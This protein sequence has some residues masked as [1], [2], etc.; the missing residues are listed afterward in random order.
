M[1]G[2]NEFKRISVLTSILAVII[3][4]VAIRVYFALFFGFDWDSSILLYQ[5]QLASQG[6]TMFSQIRVE[7]P[8]YVY[9]LA[10]M[11]PIFGAQIWIFKILS[12]LSSLVIAFFVYLIGR[13]LFGKKIGLLSLSLYLLIPVV[14]IFDVQGTYRTVFQVPVVASLFLVLVGL[15]SGRRMLLVAGGLLTGISVFLYAGSLFYGLLVLTVP[16]VYGIT[17]SA[18]KAKASLTVFIGLLIGFGLGI[19]L[20]ILLGSS[21]GLIG[22]G[23][24][25]SIT[26][27]ASGTGG[28]GGRFSSPS[29]FVNYLAYLTRYVYV[30]TRDWI[31]II[32][33]GILYLVAFMVSSV[34]TSSFTKKVA[35]ISALAIAL[36]FY[37]LAAV[38][39]ISLP[40]HGDYGL[41]DVPSVFATIF[42]AE[43]LVLIPLMAVTLTRFQIKLHRNHHVMML[44]VLWLLIFLASFELPHGFYFQFFAAPLCILGGYVVQIV[45]SHNS[46]GIGKQRHL[47]AIVLVIFISA[48][49]VLGA[50]MFV[51]SNINEWSL[52]AQ[53]VSDVGTYLRMHTYPGDYVFTAAPIY[54]EAADRP[55]AGNMDNYFYFVNSGTTSINYSLTVSKIYSL[56]QNGAVKYVILDPIG[57]TQAFIGHYPQIQSFFQDNYR[58]TARIDGA[59]IWEFQLGF[60]LSNHLS[61]VSAYTGASN[62][63]MRNQAWYYE[64]DPLIFAENPSDGNA[65][66]QNTVLP[67]QTAFEPPPTSSDGHNSSFIKMRFSNFQYSELD[68]M[69]A[70]PDVAVQGGSAGVRFEIMLSANG[71]APYEGILNV[72][73]D[74]NYWS[75]QTIDLS[76]YQGENLTILLVST[77]LS[78]WNYSWLAIV[79]NLY[80]IPI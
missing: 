21:L 28:G 79:L 14:A 27:F 80:V 13:D 77:S 10:L 33:V 15:R 17:P 76:A 58:L 46:F 9:L 7:E 45:V 3:A 71:S 38:I 70:L 61:N 72:T 47:I 37:F 35:A 49:S 67:G 41:F 43:I 20:L 60:S 26:T 75:T 62:Y 68:V 24:L 34:R 66:V 69:Y 50:I 73:V 11:L 4:G 57:R 52:S 6:A 54:A 51:N 16:F 42:V 1:R 74:N 65:L 5:A 31:P 78:Q 12:G 44:W 30:Q 2:V 19:S 29:S 64:N 36:C 48:S 40:P 55:N 22:S 59:S 23:W 53:Q 63:T 8:L 39:G 25:P 56:M 18:K 32:S